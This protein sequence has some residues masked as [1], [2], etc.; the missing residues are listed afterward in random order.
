M[1]DTE[2]MILVFQYSDRLVS[3]NYR[4]KFYALCLIWCILKE[5]YQVE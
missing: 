3:F 4:E 5:V 1:N 2:L